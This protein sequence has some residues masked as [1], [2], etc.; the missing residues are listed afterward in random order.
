MVTV[1]SKLSD[2]ML[3]MLFVFISTIV[4]NAQDKYVPAVESF[5]SKSVLSFY[6]QSAGN[7]SISKKHK[8]YGDSSLKWSWSQQSSFG[9]AHFKAVSMEESPLA[10]GSYFP[11]S[12][13]LNIS[14]YNEQ[15]K[16]D[17]ITISFEKE[18]VQQVYFN[19]ELSFTGWRRVW[20]PFYEMY[21]NAPKKGEAIDYDYFKVSTTSNQGELFFDD[22]VFS[23]YQDD[24]HQY[25]DEIVPF[26]K[27]DKKLREDFWMPLASNFNRIKNLEVAPISVAT[28]LE[29]NKFQSIIT[30]DLTV[31]AKYKTYINSLKS[32]FDEMGIYE[33]DGIVLGPPLTVYEEQEFF[34][35]NQQGK[36]RYNDVKKFGAIMRKLS[37]FH[38]RSTPEETQEIERM[39]VLGTKYFLDQGWQAGSNGGTR[40]HVGYFV[41][42]IAEGFYTMRKV[43]YQ[44]GLLSDVANSM[45]WL[46]NL[47]MLLDDES[48]FH[49]NIDY[50]NTQS[51]YHLMLIFLEENQEKQAALLKAYSNYMSVVLAQQNEPRGFKVDGTS[52]HHNG[53]YPAYGFG[54]FQNVPKVIKTLSRTRFRIRTQGHQNFKNAFLKT[55]EYSQVFN[56]GFGNAGRHPL[57]NN[58]I[59]SLR[60]QYLMMAQAGNPQGSSKIDHDFAAAYIRLWGEEDVLNSS[61]FRDI[62][63]IKKQKLKSYMT[64]PYAATAIH[65]NNDDWAA[66]VKGYSKYVWASEIYVDENRYGR[67]PSNGTIQLLNNKGESGS[68]F[69]QEGWDWN[70]Y[71]GATVIYL[72][73][74]ELEPKKPLLMFRSDETF[75]GATELNGNGIFGMV[76]NE[77]SGSNADGENTKNGYPGKLKAKK[78]M[79]SFGDKII[80]IGT[81]ISSVDTVNATQT[82]L[83]QSFLNEPKQ[84]LYS[85]EGKIKKIPSL[86]KLSETTSGNNW[87]IDPYG[88]G[89]Y[90]LSKNETYIQKKEQES[91]HNKYSIN[92]GKM[93]AKGKGVTETKGNYAA[94]WMD[95][96]LAPKNASYQYVIYPFLDEKH[97]NKFEQIAKEDNTYNVLRA[98]EVAHIVKDKK[99]STTGYVVFEAGKNL[100]NGLLKQVAEPCLVM[101]NE[102]NINSIKISA[103]QPDL[104]F[105]EKENEKGRYKNFSRSVSLSITLIGK[106]N[107]V[108]TDVVKS[109]THVN[110]NTTVLLSCKD[111]LPRE[112][113][114]QK[115]E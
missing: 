98:D 73:F 110:G 83:F 63:G 39:F 27:E 82:N 95:H 85:S 58:G 65:R 67:Y 23:Q 14:I 10:Y 100:E 2:R 70:R 4:A 72:P 43:L 52:W 104:N 38:D 20:V 48:T 91:Y 107:G 86:V 99:L 22:I 54:A 3:C 28:R 57:E 7:L 96:G 87:V 92:T 74:K 61:I 56:W 103:V 60:S 18:G 81:N 75:A 49:V 84:T 29:L 45:H 78:S 19:I 62:E 42:G 13:T 59:E 79:F 41:R 46:F 31:P 94:G 113:S 109:I 30:Q 102:S 15:A 21:G 88:N 35:K 5:E 47:G 8:R 105:E 17:T 80:A 55:S 26:I 16:N 40:H 69:K 9:T 90:I 66:I 33:K 64:M 68:G 37:H 77:S 50:L 36:R 115:T 1:L 108:E 12:P 34:D 111:G 93:N 51:Y 32:D 25:P 11:A 106:W 71:P 112:F 114:L 44:E 53:H 89:Y 76:L 101:I 24:R 97:Q 6:N